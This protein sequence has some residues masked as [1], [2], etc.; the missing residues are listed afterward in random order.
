MKHHLQHLAGAF[1]ITEEKER[2]LFTSIFAGGETEAQIG[3]GS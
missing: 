3:R 1:Q 2:Q